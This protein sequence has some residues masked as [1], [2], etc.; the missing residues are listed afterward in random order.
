MRMSLVS[1]VVA[2]GKKRTLS[3]ATVNN[4]DAMGFANQAPLKLACQLPSQELR[5]MMSSKGT[6]L[7]RIYRKQ[8]TILFTVKLKAYIFSR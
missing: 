4:F 5:R 2:G 1:M 6:I 3:L 7:R 8:E